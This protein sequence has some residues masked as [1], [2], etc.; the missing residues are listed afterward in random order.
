MP[1]TNQLRRSMR[2]IR[3]TPTQRQLRHKIEAYHGHAAA[4]PKAAVNFVLPYLGNADRFIRY[5]ARVALEFQPI[6]LWQDRVLAASDPETLIT[7]AVAIA[8]Q[9]TAAIQPKLL[10]AL[11]AVA[12]DKLTELQQLE[13][14]RAYGLRSS[15]LVSPTRH[16]GRQ[17]PRNLMHSFQAR[18]NW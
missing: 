9:G 7:G 13:L 15:A 1:A 8:H 16:C 2:T 12:F 14:L 6:A 18:T 17:S 11:D 10:A 4:D 5:A 3:E